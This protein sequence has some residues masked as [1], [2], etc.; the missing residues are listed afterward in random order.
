[1]NDTSVS[2][3]RKNLY[4]K[5]LDSNENRRRRDEIQVKIR[6]DKKIENMKKRRAMVPSNNTI[7]SAGSVTDSVTGSVT[8]NEITTTKIYTASDIPS[9][10]K[11]LNSSVKDPNQVLSLLESIRGFR[12][13][14]S[15]EHNPPVM[16][17]LESGSVPTLI[18]LLLH[19]TSTD[20]AFEA[21]WALTNIASTQH[22]KLLVEEGIIPPLVQLLRSANPELRDQSIWCLGNIAGDCTDL[23]DTVLQSG[24]MTRILENI[25]QPASP[26]LL[27]N[28]V[29]TLSNLCR[30]K[31]PHVSLE[32]VSPAIPQLVALITQGHIPVEVKID[33][34]WAISYI[35][36]GDE[37]R[38]QTI[39]DT[40]ITPILVENLACDDIMVVTPCLRA[41]GNFVSGNDEQTQVVIN[42]KIMD[43]IPKLLENT[44][45]SVRREA[46]W[47]LSNIAAGNSDQIA[48]LFLRSNRTILCSIIKAVQHEA[49]EVRKEAVWVVTNIVSGGKDYFVQSLVSNKAIQALCSVVDMHDT[50]ISLIV[51]DA[52]ETILKVAEKLGLM[53]EYQRYLDEAG[54]IEKLEECQSHA[55]EEVYEK[56]LQIIDTFFGEEE[57]EHEN[58]APGTEGNRF[59]FGAPD[60]TKE[61]ADANVT[62]P[63]PLQCTENL[64]F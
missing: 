16:E 52:I 4:K 31:P 64:Q 42:Y 15:A 36:D 28:A 7:M 39:I 63:E 32:H 21:A 37:N 19:P 58:L 38:I 2:A 26:S 3:R 8:G 62:I 34:C 17:V 35:C 13:M 55:S 12:R 6:K 46:Y 9:L 41:L 45:N 18:E 47:L 49:W 44:K 61:S 48:T 25:A 1:M 51:L 33:A 54:G 27:G 29:W 57:L 14:L 22:T 40:N 20:I 60:V 11:S 10:T 30:G 59:V 43:Y 24:V 23:R 5:G 50:K 56:S 53:I